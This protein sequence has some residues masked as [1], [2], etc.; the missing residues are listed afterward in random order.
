MFPSQSDPGVLLLTQGFTKD[1]HQ[2]IWE[3]QNDK[4]LLVSTVSQSTPSLGTVSI[5][6]LASMSR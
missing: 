6:P 4:S 5:E 1:A 3:V 2:S